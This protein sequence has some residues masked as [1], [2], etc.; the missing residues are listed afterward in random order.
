MANYTLTGGNSMDL[1]DG[2][3]WTDESSN[4]G[5]A[6][7]AGDHAIIEDGNWWGYSAGGNATWGSLYI[8][9]LNNPPDLGSVTV[10]GPITLDGGALNSVTL[11]SG[12]SVVGYGFIGGGG[13]LSAGSLVAHGGLLQ[14]ASGGPPPS[15]GVQID[16]GASVDPGNQLF[17][18]ASAVDVAGPVAAQLA[19]DVAAVNAGKADIKTT[20]TI[21]GVAGTFDVAGYEAGRNTDPGVAHVENGVQ[22]KFLSAAN[23]RTGTL[24]AGSGGMPGVVIV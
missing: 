2:L 13:N 9:A 17:C 19:A 5:T 15:N 16:Q 7:G 4:T 23:N 8:A 24:V 21:L 22:W 3:N 20:R 6:P 14:F 10:A 11:G 18:S 12:G 1:L